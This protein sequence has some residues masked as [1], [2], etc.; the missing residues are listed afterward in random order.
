MAG[1]SIGPRELEIIVGIHQLQ[2]WPANF[3]IKDDFEEQND[4]YCDVLQ[5]KLTIAEEKDGIYSLHW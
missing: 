4:L 3:S 2:Y 1:Y 5:S